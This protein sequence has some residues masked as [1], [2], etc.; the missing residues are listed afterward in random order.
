MLVKAFYLI[1][2]DLSDALLDLEASH[3]MPIFCTA[4][5]EVDVAPVRDFGLQFKHKKYSL[6]SFSSC[7]MSISD[8]IEG[9]GGETTIVNPRLKSLLEVRCR[10]I[11]YG[12]MFF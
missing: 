8:S 11:L 3:K 10:N 2:I 6:F 7:R 1:S 4:L 5:F 12:Y 9:V